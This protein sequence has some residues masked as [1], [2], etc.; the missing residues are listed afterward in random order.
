MEEGADSLDF[1]SRHLRGFHGVEAD[2]SQV[3]EEGIREALLG[4]GDN[5]PDV[6]RD[7]RGE[8]NV[9]PLERIPRSGSRC[10]RSSAG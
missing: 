7:A 4:E 8:N 1:P 5:S 2:V 9:L 10:A 6:N 3:I